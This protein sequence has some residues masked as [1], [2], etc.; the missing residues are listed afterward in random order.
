MTFV[1]TWLS[2]FVVKSPNHLKTCNQSQRLVSSEK[3]KKPKEE[4]QHGYVCTL[5]VTL[6]NSF[7]FIR[8]K[9]EI[10]L[11]IILFST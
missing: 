9:S 11:H 3:R 10:K 6:Q 5:Y 4:K 1:R 2:L 7:P 8:H